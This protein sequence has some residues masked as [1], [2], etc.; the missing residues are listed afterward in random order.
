MTV[1]PSLA[2][3]AGL[4]AVAVL[5]WPRPSRAEGLPRSRSASALRRRRR[6]WWRWRH[7]HSSAADVDALLTLLDAVGP[8]LRAGLAPGDALR[9]VAPDGAARPVGPDDAAEGAGRHGSSLA[10][11]TPERFVTDL[12]RG[13]DRA[14]PL[15][16]VWQEW[17]TR[18]GSSD[19][20]LVASAWALCERLG[21]PLAAT[22]ATVGSVVRRRAEVERRTAAALAGPRASMAVLTALPAAGPLLALVMGLSPLDLYASPPGAAALGAGLVL[23]LV[24]RWWGARLVRSIEGPRRAGGSS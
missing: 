22:V 9:A 3:G 21:A 17:A 24:G 8:A 6:P 14:E 11:P 13:A 5:V 16:P 1:T 23:L 7:R 20:R 12:L 18:T 2:V 15:A 19:L 4:L 10:W